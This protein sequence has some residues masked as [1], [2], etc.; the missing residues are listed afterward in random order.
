MNIFLILGIVFAVS[1]III[2]LVGMTYNMRKI[3]SKKELI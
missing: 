2:G 3:E 1:S